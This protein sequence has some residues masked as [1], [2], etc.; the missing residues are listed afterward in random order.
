MI[1]SAEYFG[2]SFIALFDVKSS[3]RR[4]EAFKIVK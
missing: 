2:H 4:F 3:K 1:A